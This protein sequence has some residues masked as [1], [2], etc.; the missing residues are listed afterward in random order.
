MV[1][2]DCF[3]NVH[4][5]FL[6]PSSST[7]INV[8][9]HFIQDP[10]VPAKDMLFSVGLHPW[11]LNLFS[12]KI[13]KEK[14]LEIGATKHC[15][16]IGE[17]GL[18]KLRGGLI[19]EQKEIFLIHIDV[20]EELKKPLIIHNVKCSDI[21]IDI[22]K[23]YKPQQPWI[24]HGFNQKKSVANELIKQNCWLSFGRA[25]F[26]KQSPAYDSFFFVSEERWLLETD[27]ESEISIEEIYARAGEIKKISV[28][29]IIEISNK[30][31][32]SLFKI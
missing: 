17:T 16:F 7:H 13:L 30:N 28:E 15:C 2:K 23:K 14:L 3:I 11:H 18:D 1:V 4:S 31:F 27:D 5:H 29:K 25:L 26:N 21:L 22:K 9:N 24:F 10:V 20:A 6:R 19:E 8:Y 32:N 12:K